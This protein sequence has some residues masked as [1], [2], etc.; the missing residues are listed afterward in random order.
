MEFIMGAS[1]QT[2]VAGRILAGLVFVAM[3]L[4]PLLATFDIGPLDHND[5]NG[6]AWL[7]FASGGIFVTAGLALMVG[8]SSPL[9]NGLLALLSTAGLA[10][11][12]NWIAFG[13]GE[14][15]CSGSVSVG[16]FW[17]DAQISDLSCRI[18]FGMGAL[19]IDGFLFV[20]SVFYLQKALGGPPKLAKLRR[21]SE[22]FLV[23]SLAPLLLTL[24]IIMV[25]QAGGGAIR[26][27]L[28]TGKWPR[29][30]EFIARQ[31]A[32]ELFN[33]LTKEIYQR[34]SR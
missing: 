1:Q 11:I 7:G 28:T 2:P 27:R 12:S 22:I 25:V 34:Q 5:I 24:A 16:W 10:A 26:A 9:L 21:A 29:N 4:F 14:R 32:K 17:S 6:P 8:E 31:K 30:E 19:F 13:A 3:G 33:K 18:P 15:V 20:F 23:V